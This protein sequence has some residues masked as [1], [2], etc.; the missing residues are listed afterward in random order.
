MNAPRRIRRF[1]ALLLVFSLLLTGC[2]QEGT[3]S[4]TTSSAENGVDYNRY[5]ANRGAV[6]YW[7]GVLILFRRSS[8]LFEMDPANP[9]EITPLC[10]R[11][12]CDHRGGA[13]SAYLS[14]ISAYVYDGKIYYLDDMDADT[15]EIGLYRMDPGGTEREAVR[16]LKD[17]I[18][19]NVL[20]GYG[21][22]VG[23]GYL[24]IRLIRWKDDQRYDLLYL[25]QLEQLDADPILV[26]SGEETMEMIPGYR[27][28]DDWVFYQRY[29]DAEQT[30][31]LQAYRI[32]T[33]ETMAINEQGKC[34][35]YSLSGS[36]LYWC[37]AASGVSSTDLLTGEETLYQALNPPDWTTRED[38]YYIASYDER[39]LYLVADGLE[40]DSE[41]AQQESCLTICDY[42]GNVKQTLSYEGMNRGL[43][44]SCSTPDR[45]FFTRR[46]SADSFP[47][48]YLEKSAIETGTAEFVWLDS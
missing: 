6:G 1:I 48:C 27:V 31:R 18:P 45:V 24:L 20:N 28:M 44:Y 15:N 33:G 11:A 2:G 42:E 23:D 35:S 3:L 12:D 21:Y 30:Y 10:T 19:Q 41:Q 4:S 14:A 34:L 17:V 36:T 47:V 26:Y 16:S 39:F 37:D 5:S 22:E 8:E 43:R 29:T 32:S 40:S 25:L 13:C 9:E 7:D 38:C 46:G